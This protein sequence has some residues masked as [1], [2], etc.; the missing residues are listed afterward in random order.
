MVPRRRAR[1]RRLPAT[2]MTRSTSRSRVV[3]AV[4]G[5][6]AA[7]LCVRLGFWQLGRLSEVRDARAVREARLQLPAVPLSAAFGSDAQASASLEAW[8][9]VSLSGRWDYRGEVLIRSRSLNGRP[10]IH[11]VTPLVLDGE[12]TPGA[13]SAESVLVLRGWLPSPDAMHPGPLSTTEPG[14]P[15]GA[16]GVLQA[17]RDGA[18]LPV[19]PA[20]E[21]PNRRPTMAAVDVPAIREAIR[22]DIARPGGDRAGGARPSE[23]YFVRLLPPETASASAAG[24]PVPVPLPPADD[25][26]HLGYAIQ[27]FSFALIALVGCG[28]FLLQGRRRQPSTSP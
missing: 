27:W 9:R 19:L 23:R 21:G 1:P 14:P 12:G 22:A 4:L 18:G 8:R 11:V 3:F 25:G 20:G 13:P 6:L 26:P 5:L 24:V 17:S 16:V 15:A 2:T 28:A 7:L 10:G